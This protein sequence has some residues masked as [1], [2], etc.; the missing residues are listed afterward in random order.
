V[1]PSLES[2]RLRRITAAYTINRLG[3]WVGHVALAL[4]VFDDTGSAL[5]VAALFLAWL[6]LPSFVVPALVAR[7][8]ASARRRELSGL[9]LFEAVAT[10]ALA[11]VLLHF[12]LP[13]VL[14]IAAMDGTAALASSALLRAEI[15]KVARQEAASQAPV[16]SPIEA[17][18]D[19][20]HQAERITNARLNVCFSVAFV[21]GPVLGSAIVATAGTTAALFVDVGSFLICGAFVLDLHPHVEEASGDSVRARLRAA[22][23]HIYT[24]PS[25]RSLLLVEAVALVF[26]E[27]GGPI[28]VGYAKATLHAGDRGYGLLLTAWGL[29][30]VLGSVAFARLSRRPLQ[31]M[32]GVSVFALGGAFVGFAVAPTLL[33]A[34]LAAVAGGVGNG[35]EWPSLISLVQHMTPVRLHGRIMGAVESLAAICL[36]TG[37]PLGGALVGL[38]SSRLAFL[39]IGIGAAATAPA[40]LRVRIGPESTMAASV[41]AG[42]SEDSSPHVSSGTPREST[43]T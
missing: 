40:F 42:L 25:L 23:G 34:C 8:E 19:M 9:Y 3:S 4:A 7:V 22:W 1:R 24:V 20:C 27:A 2:L 35:I 39:V 43:P 16:G 31:Q 21:I 10:A 30:A 38:S 37:L 26:I 13:V 14:L 12:W 11:V 33:L 18:E 36:A 41:D 5:A 32:L 28:E 29:G 15:A 6:A 17:V